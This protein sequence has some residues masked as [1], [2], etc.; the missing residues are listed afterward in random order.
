SGESHPRGERIEREKGDGCEQRGVAS[1]GEDEEPGEEPGRRPRAHHGAS[2]LRAA[3]KALWKKHQEHGKQGGADDLR[4][5]VEGGNLPG[6]GFHVPPELLEVHAKAQRRVPGHILTGPVG[7][8]GAKPGDVLEIRIID[9]ALRQ[10]WGYTYVRPLAG[11]LP[12]DFEDFEQI[13]TRL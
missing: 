8:G 4:G 11:A 2:A 6:D 7:V 13:H 10:D 5:A 12:N 1:D 3:V 9:V